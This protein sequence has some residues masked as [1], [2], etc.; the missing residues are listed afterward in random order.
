MRRIL[1]DA[2]IPSQV[3]YLCSVV[4]LASARFPQNPKSFFLETSMSTIHP[5]DRA[6]LCS[7]TFVEGH[8]CRI[9]RRHG[10]PYLCTF[11]ARREAKIFTRENVGEEIA[12]YLSG[13]Q[14]PAGGLCFALG[15]LF[16]AVAQG[17]VEPKTVA[18]LAHLGRSLVQ[19]L[20]VAREE[21][22]IASS[23]ASGESAILRDTPRPTPINPREASP[24]PRHPHLP[25]K[26][27]VP[28]NSETT[29]IIPSSPNLSESTLPKV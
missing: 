18:A 20:H 28:L 3:H 9:P 15:R 25:P 29:P 17:E 27:R 2:A 23:P 21:C 14:V 16:A 22:A 8:R 10:H 24:T 26:H 6:S 7:F 4:R 13:E 5:E 1:I 11:H 19:A 12:R